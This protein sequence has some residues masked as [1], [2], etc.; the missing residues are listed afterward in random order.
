MEVQTRR[1]WWYALPIVGAA[2]PIA[3]M[4]TRR[5]GE[6]PCVPKESKEEVLLRESNIDLRKAM[7][8]ALKYVAGTPVEVEL[9]ESNGM[10][11]W[12]VQVVPK[13]GGPTREVLIDAK[14]GDLL[15]MKAEQSGKMKCE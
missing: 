7:D 9:E 14:S 10:P 2:I 3:L 1:N 11:V 15:E 6:E 8:T 12:E 13:H 5:F 4:L